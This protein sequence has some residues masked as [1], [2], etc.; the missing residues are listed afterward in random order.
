MRPESTEERKLRVVDRDVMDEKDP[1]TL[2]VRADAEH[3]LFFH[4]GGTKRDVYG[5][6]G[7][8][9][10]FSSLHHVR[11]DGLKSEPETPVPA[12]TSTRAF[13]SRNERSSFFAENLGG[14]EIPLRAIKQD[15]K[16]PGTTT[17]TSK[18]ARNR[19]RKAD[20]RT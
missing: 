19:E 1:L 8:T 10:F 9:L 6:P 11:P 16:A 5:H 12:R 13:A 14:S 20:P 7:R 2:H 3:S 15:F 17:T 18:R 4:F